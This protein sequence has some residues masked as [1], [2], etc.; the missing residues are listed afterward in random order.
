MG[1]G[2]EEGK[3]KGIACK[4]VYRRGKKGRREGNGLEGR[5]ILAGD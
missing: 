3:N 5:V 2:K 4:G 1:E